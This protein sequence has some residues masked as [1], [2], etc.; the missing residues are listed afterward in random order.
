M[1]T[2]SLRFGKRRSSGATPLSV[3]EDAD[4]RQYVEDDSGRVY[5]TWLPSARRPTKVRAGRSASL[6]PPSGTSGSV[7]YR[8]ARTAAGKRRRRQ[9]ARRGDAA[10]LLGHAWIAEANHKVERLAG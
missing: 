4:S 8:R 3:F 9:A 5:G 10:C 1:A 2:P 6:P 7:R